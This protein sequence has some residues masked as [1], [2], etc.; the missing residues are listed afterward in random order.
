MQITK[1]IL[2]ARS[3]N[4]LRRFSVF[5]LIVLFFLI[6]KVPQ[7][8][9]LDA[10]RQLNQVFESTR[11]TERETS[12]AVRETDALTRR[13]AAPI[14]FA[15]WAAA[16]KVKGGLGSR[17][18]Y[19]CGATLINAQWALTEANCVDGVSPKDVS[20]QYGSDIL[21]EAQT[22]LVDKITIHPSYLRENF[23]NSIALIRL[24]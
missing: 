19:F 6:L 15:P 20:L 8:V 24:A 4:R 11:G 16:L 22:A 14:A 18:V 2:A 21:S 5:L 1:Q 17:E 10:S 12:R 3:E 23:Q 7:T 9:A 13:F